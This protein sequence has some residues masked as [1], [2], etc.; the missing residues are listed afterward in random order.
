ME[1]SRFRDGGSGPTAPTGSS[2]AGLLNTAR[3]QRTC[4]SRA[5]QKRTR[6]GQF[7]GTSRRSSSNQFSKRRAV[8]KPALLVATPLVLQ[9]TAGP[10]P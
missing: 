4:Q 7:T 6:A 2:P 3:L 9:P 10:S 5:S 1:A 8:F